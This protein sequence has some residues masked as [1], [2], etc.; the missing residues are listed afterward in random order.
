M[1]DVVGLTSYSCQRITPTLAPALARTSRL[2]ILHCGRSSSIHYP[3]PWLV[4]CLV[5]T[6][7]VQ[8]GGGDGPRCAYLRNEKIRPRFRKPVPRDTELGIET[9]S[10]PSPVANRSHANLFRSPRDGDKGGYFFFVRTPIAIFLQSPPPT[11]SR[12]IGLWIP[13][14]RQILHRGELVLL[15]VVFFFLFGEIQTNNPFAD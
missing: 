6:A 4:S 12:L 15:Q 5:A 13:I 10:N 14:H 11:P 2:K 9:K 1:A 7:T 8:P 3:A